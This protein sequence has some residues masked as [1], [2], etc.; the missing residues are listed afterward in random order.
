MIFTITQ[1][2]YQALQKQWEEFNKFA[3]LIIET[4][5]HDIFTWNY[6]FFRADEDFP[7]DFHCQTVNPLLNRL[8]DCCVISDFSLRELYDD[9]F[10]AYYEEIDLKIKTFQ[11]E[12]D[13]YEWR[14]IYAG[15]SYD[16]YVE[17]FN[18]AKESEADA[19]NKAYD[20]LTENGFKITK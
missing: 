13:S 19:L 4:P 17:W 14:C 2:S 12:N 9:E 7:F 1:E 16:F 6:S 3:P 8:R 11:E 18:N 15:D 20:L 10:L 5:E